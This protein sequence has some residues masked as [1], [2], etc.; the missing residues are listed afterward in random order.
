[1]VTQLDPS[2]FTHQPPL[3]LAVDDD[4]NTT[5]MLETIFER[6]GFQV[7][8]VNNG[9]AALT[10]ATALLPDLILLDYMMP[11]MN[12]FDVLRT[13]REQPTTK[14][15][16]T[17]IVTAQARQPAD[18]EM[19]L[20]LG[21]D[22]YLY[23]PFNPQELIARAMSKIKARK[24]EEDLERRTRELEALLRVSE[25]FN[26]YV[27]ID[28]LLSLIPDL[29]LDL[30]PAAA[31][32]IYLFD[33]DGRLAEVRVRARATLSNPAALE[34]ATVVQHILQ[35]L[36]TPQARRWTS[37]AP[38]LPVFPDGMVAP[39]EQGKHVHGLLMLVG[40]DPFDDYR[41]RL[42]QGIARQAAL[43]L[44][45]A[46]LYEM[47]ARYA[48]ELEAAVEART[49]DLQSA[50]QLLIRQE[51][52]ASLGHL[53]A[54]IAHEINNPLMPIKNLLEDLLED[55]E[56]QHVQF[57]AK[58]ISIIQE[59]LERIRRIV[60]QLLDFTGRRQAGPELELLEI[61]PILE[62]IIELNR[63]YFEQSN[64]KIVVDLPKLPPVFGSKDQLEQV[65]MNLAIN[66]QA[67]MEGGGLLKVSARQGGDQ[68]VVDFEDNGSGIAP[69]HIERIFDPFF[70]TKPTG[71]G[72]G[73]FVSYGI[74]QGHNGTIAVQSKLN[75]GTRF[76]VSL[77][78]HHSADV[79]PGWQTEG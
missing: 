46:E 12:G 29:A 11:G 45:N 16:P 36:G 41:L 6:A 4:P 53:A 22:D 79:N 23:K 59:S 43:A 57:D 7:A 52:L 42:F 78:I 54:S 1:M 73:L 66:A 49:K 69:E 21:A 17:I 76:T 3:V 26:Q 34:D 15:I 40:H 77:P 50:Q 47:Q 32:V 60:R 39:L 68:I 30:I 27:H 75:K 33:K 70:S 63:K 58:A 67:A 2:L 18:V 19:G 62:G 28:D 65:F 64:I 38:L 55:L 51:K 37:D 31:G 74:V 25:Q 72:L 13:L 5:S 48:Q 44:G 56:H 10:Q 24:L 61:S 20:N 71:T 14:N 35:W 8:K 9:S